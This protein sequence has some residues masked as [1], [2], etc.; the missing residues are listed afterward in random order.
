MRKNRLRTEF[1]SLMDETV[2]ILEATFFSEYGSC[3]DEVLQRVAYRTVTDGAKVLVCPEPS[4]LVDVLMDVVF[5]SVNQKRVLLP[6]EIVERTVLRLEQDRQKY[7]ADAVPVE[8][9]GS[10]LKGIWRVIAE[11]YF[12]HHDEN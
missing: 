9:V 2:E 6:E 5:D 8:P 3:I 10:S 4:Q 1:G 12:H 7:V 11:N